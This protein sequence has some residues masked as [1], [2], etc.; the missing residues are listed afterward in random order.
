MSVNVGSLDRAFRVV[1]GLIL[2]VAAFAG[3]L[4][5]FGM[6]VS[7][8]VG[9]VLVVTALFRFCPLY[10]VIGLRTCKV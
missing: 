10:R 8:I 6:I 7:V 1:L 4:G 5:L 3:N 9:A 2:V